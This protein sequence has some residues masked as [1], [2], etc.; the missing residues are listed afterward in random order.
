MYTYD[1]IKQI[2][3]EKIAAMNKEA[4][5]P[6]LVSEISPLA[7]AGIGALTGAGIGALKERLTTPEE[8]RN[9]LGSTLLGAAGG[10]L[11]SLAHRGMET[12]N[13]KTLAS[14]GLHALVPGAALSSLAP[15]QTGMKFMTQR[16]IAELEDDVINNPNVAPD[17]KQDIQQYIDLQKRQYGL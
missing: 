12:R 2:A 11:G 10:L 6:G 8:E 5:L 13:G 7:T 4:G 14:A 15:D 17:I 16:E 9:Y 3:T 1:L